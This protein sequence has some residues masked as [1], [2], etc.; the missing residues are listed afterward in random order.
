MSA[1]NLPKLVS[2]PVIAFKALQQ[3]RIAFIKLLFTSKLALGQ[4][5]ERWLAG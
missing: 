3:L 1:E 2:P 4:V 5:N